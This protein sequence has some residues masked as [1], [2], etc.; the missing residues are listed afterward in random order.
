ME[1]F[2]EASQENK[3]GGCAIFFLN[4]NHHFQIQMGLGAGTNNYAELMAL[5]ILL[6]FALEKDCRRI[7]IFWDSLVILNWVKKVE[8]CRNI[9]LFHSLKNLIDSQKTLTMLHAVMFTGKGT[10]M[11]IAYPK[12]G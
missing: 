3:C 5:I 6:C 1:F 9:L 11:M 4:Q 7:H 12:M 10:L 8:R 2:N